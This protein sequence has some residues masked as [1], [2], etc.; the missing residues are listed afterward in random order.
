MAVRSIL[1]GATGTCG[2]RCTSLRRLFVHDDVYKKLVPV[3]VKAYKQI[4]VGDPLDK[5]TL[6]GP[7]IDKAS[8]VRSDAKRG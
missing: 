5:K 4:R 1:F 3:L 2:Q 8:S 7:L 6:V